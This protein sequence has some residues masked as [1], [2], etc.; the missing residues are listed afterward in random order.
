[1]EKNIIVTG[2]SGGIGKSIVEKLAQN[3]CNIWACCS[4]QHEAFIAWIK[5]LQE[6]YRVWIKNVTFDLS[7]EKQI[8]EAFKSIFADKRDIH[9]LVNNAGI[10]Y[11]GMLQTT[12]V[13]DLRR[14]MEVNFISQISVMQIASRKMMRQKQGVIVNVGSVGGIEARPGYLAYGS[15]KAALLWATR[16]ISKE[17]APYNIRVNAIAP[18]LI[19][20]DMG[21]YKPQKAQEEIINGNSMKRMG[22]P[23]EIADLVYYL[24]S[25]QASFI[26]GTIV[27]VD[28]GRLM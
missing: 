24:L 16:S 28:G 13:D 10:P 19:D 7:D 18:G 9:G 6:T 11:N 2:A 8:K 21:H 23:S 22:K 17:L 12:P 20:T 4:S 26:T 3:G 14:V 27:N 15:S 1:M 25:D 5:E